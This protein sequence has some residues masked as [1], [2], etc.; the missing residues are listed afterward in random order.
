LP[1]R[2][3]LRGSRR[4]YCAGSHE[5]LPGGQGKPL[6]LSQPGNANIAIYLAA[7]GLHALEYTGRGV[8]YSDTPS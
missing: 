8:G 2:R 7:L 5:L 6:R 4:R 1:F 3:R